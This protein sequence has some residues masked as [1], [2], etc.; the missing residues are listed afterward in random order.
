MNTL[1][2]YKGISLV[3]QGLKSP[4]HTVG[5][6]ASLSRLSV[7][8]WRWIGRI[9]WF[10]I[11]HLTRSDGFSI[12]G[13]RWVRRWRIVWRGDSADRV[14]RRTRVNGRR[15]RI[16]WLGLHGVGASLH[17]I[18]ASRGLHRIARCKWKGQ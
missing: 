10:R 8:G 18:G 3:Y 17:G 16:F 12:L 13:R 2:D 15:L 14:G 11:W 5:L 9:C 6:H 7:S 4:H 1:T